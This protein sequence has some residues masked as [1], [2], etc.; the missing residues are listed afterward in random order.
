M[1]IPTRFRRFSKDWDE[2]N[3][4]PPLYHKIP[5]GEQYDRADVAGKSG[6][7]RLATHT[8]PD[9]SYTWPATPCHPSLRVVWEHTRP[10]PQGWISNLL[11]EPIQTA[12]A[13]TP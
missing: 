1:D 9:D 3:V 12:P 7:S 10:K 8:K 2:K 13:T 11:M 6:W 4:P 5:P